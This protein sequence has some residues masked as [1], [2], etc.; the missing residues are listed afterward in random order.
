M[1]THYRPGNRGFFQRLDD[2]QEA[3]RERINQIRDVGGLPEIEA[4]TP[5]YGLPYYTERNGAGY[6]L[7]ISA[8]RGGY[9]AN[10]E[11]NRE[12]I[13]QAARRFWYGAYNPC[14]EVISVHDA[15][16]QYVT[17]HWFDAWTNMRRGPEPEDNASA[18]HLLTKGNFG[19]EP[20]PI[21]TKTYDMDFFN[22]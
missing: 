19:E 13:A 1:A 9:I 18:V 5:N 17:Q 14:A 15:R 20:K 11:V 3:R 10:T 8:M 12:A 6:G 2:R 21:S 22:F 7:P 16:E 4:P